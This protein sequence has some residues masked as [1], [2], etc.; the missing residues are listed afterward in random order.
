MNNEKERPV[1]V[2]DNNYSKEA[3]Y[4][5]SVDVLIQKLEYAMENDMV[6]QPYKMK[7]LINDVKVKKAIMFGR[8]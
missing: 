6:L 7:E 2:S 3:E 8:N 4:I 1:N 5:K